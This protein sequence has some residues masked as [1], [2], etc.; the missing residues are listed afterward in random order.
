[1]E[2]RVFY[3]MRSDPNIPSH[4]ESRLTFSLPVFLSFQIFHQLWFDCIWLGICVFWLW[5]I[6]CC[7]D[8]ASAP[9][10]YSYNFSLGSGRLFFL[11][12]YILKCNLFLIFHF[13]SLQCHIILQKSFWYADLLLKKHFLLLSYYQWWKQLCCLIFLWIFFFCGTFPQKFFK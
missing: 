11:N 3:Q 4:W 1:M 6:Q 9:Y 10:S 13:T 2:K 7:S 12:K 5:S 8:G